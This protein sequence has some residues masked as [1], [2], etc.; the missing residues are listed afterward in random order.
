MADEPPFESPHYERCT[1]PDCPVRHAYDVERGQPHYHFT[2]SDIHPAW[3][4]P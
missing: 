1:D 3:D 4:V 2:G